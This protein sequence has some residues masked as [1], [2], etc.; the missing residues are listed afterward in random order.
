MGTTSKTL[1]GKKNEGKKAKKKEKLEK[2]VK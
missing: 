2:E 1:I